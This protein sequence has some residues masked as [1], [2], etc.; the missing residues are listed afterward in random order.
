MTHNNWNT[1]VR[2]N[3]QYPLYWFPSNNY[4]SF[5][6]FWISHEITHIM[7]TKGFQKSGY[8]ALPKALEM[9]GYPPMTHTCQQIYYSC[10]HSPIL[11]ALND[12]QFLLLPSPL[13]PH[14]QFFVSC[15]LY[16]VSILHSLISCLNHILESGWNGFQI[17]IL[18]IQWPS[19]RATCSRL[20]RCKT[21]HHWE[22]TP[23]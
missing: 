15:I 3:A 19:W 22:Q 8:L 23:P 9:C 18:H 21:E 1:Y 14:S 2:H 5:L 13:P 10:N 6:P 7:S 11:G 12:V 17:R 4:A 16:L 20:M